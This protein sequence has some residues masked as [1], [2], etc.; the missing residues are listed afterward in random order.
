MD[1]EELY[2]ELA[3]PHAE[4]EAFTP[5][6]HWGAEVSRIEALLGRRA[7]STLDVGCRNGDL[8]LHWPE[9]TQR[10][11]VELSTAAANLA[12]QRGLEIHR[13]RLEDAPLEEPFDAVTC[14]AILEHLAEPMRFLDSLSSIVSEDGVLIVMIPSFETWKA[15]WLEALGMR[16]YMYCPPEHLTFYSRAFLDDFLGKRDFSLVQRRYTS[17]GTANPFMNV[18]LAGRAW[19]RMMRTLDSSAWVTGRPFFDHMYSYYRRGTTR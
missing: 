19:A 1:L 17:G 2:D 10:V 5:S 13:C 7:N 11:G 14:Y 18:P 8:L 3:Q 9:G 16:W 6:P 4:T 12:Q 15:R